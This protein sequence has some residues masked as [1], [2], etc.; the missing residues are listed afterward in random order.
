MTL[1]IEIP[2]DLAPHFARVPE[3]ERPKFALALI[4][5]GIE[6]EKALAELKKLEEGLGL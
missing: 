2:E 3:S 6:K 5:K 1:T 4:R